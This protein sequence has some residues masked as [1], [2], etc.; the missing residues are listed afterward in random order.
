MF[1]NGSIRS[2]CQGEVAARG[3]IGPTGVAGIELATT[4]VEADLVVA[5]AAVVSA[6]ASI[7]FIIS[8]L[9][10]RPDGPVPCIVLRSISCH[11]PQEEYTVPFGCAL[12]RRTGTDCTIISFGR[13]LHFCLE[14]AEELAKEGI[15]C[16][17]ID[18][19]TIR[20]L[21]IDSMV[22][23]VLK[24]NTCVVVDQ[25]WAFASIGSE[26]TSQIH[27]ICFDHLDNHVHR[28][29]SDDVPSPYAYNL[30]QAYLPNTRKICE[31]VRSATYNE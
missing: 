28:V 5:A 8:R 30:E 1:D 9:I 10:T 27:T 14:A 20:P 3:C 11:V 21:D 31:A 26:I 4:S 24:T 7:N 19:R 13:P 18:G 29:H 22:A 15:D 16:E 25:S 12:T 2:C 17:V 23:S 6:V